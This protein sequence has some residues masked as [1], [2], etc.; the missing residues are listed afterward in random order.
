MSVIAGVAVSVAIVTMFP[1]PTS[2]PAT[3]DLI[4]FRQ[5]NAV[6]DEHDSSEDTNDNREAHKTTNLLAD[7]KY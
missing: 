5:S 2:L 1:I 7:K 3:Y 4:E 6:T